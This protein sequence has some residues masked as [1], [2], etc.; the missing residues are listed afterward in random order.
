[1]LNFHLPSVASCTSQPA[2]MHAKP[3]LLLL[4][5]LAVAVAPFRAGLQPDSKQDKRPAPAGAVE[6]RRL[7]TPS[8]GT[9]LLMHRPDNGAGPAGD[10]LYIIPL[11]DS[12]ANL[13]RFTPW[14]MP[15]RLLGG[16]DGKCFYEAQVFVGEVLRDTVGVIW[17][18][19]SLM[20]DGRWKENTVLLNL[21]A[22][23]PDT[24]VFFGHGRRS[25]TQDLAFS[26]KCRILRGEDRQVPV[27]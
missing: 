8:G 18:D 22:S 14:H 3:A 13:E 12:T 10:G 9:W 16:G 7:S 15:G 21:N 24:A 4:L 11:A 17:Y 19:R 6:L 23:Q 1:M 26:G 2:P 27:E 20:P 5:P 25:I